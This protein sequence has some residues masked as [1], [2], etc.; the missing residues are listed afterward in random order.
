MKYEWKGN[1]YY[2]V[3]DPDWSFSSR[4]SGTIAITCVKSL[5]FLWVDIFSL[6]CPVICFDMML[7]YIFLGFLCIYWFWKE[8]K[9]ILKRLSRFFY[10]HFVPTGVPIKMGNLSIYTI[11]SLLF[12]HTCMPGGYN[13]KKLFLSSGSRENCLIL[14]FLSARV[15]LRQS[16]TQSKVMMFLF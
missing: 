2:K 16:T 9:K 13:S 4:S 6:Y 15:L 14:T 1:S 3:I 5:D 7:I 11:R 8:K 10:P 12:S